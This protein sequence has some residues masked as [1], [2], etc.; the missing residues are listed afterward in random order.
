MPVEIIGEVGTAGAEREWL[1]AQASL[2][3]KQIV[4]KCG[5]PPPEMELELLWQEHELGEYPVIG[6]TWEDGMRGAPAKYISRCQDALFEHEEGE[7][8]PAP[9]VGGIAKK[10]RTKRSPATLNTMSSSLGFIR[11]LCGR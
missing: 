4:K 8:P 10:K 2:A 9:I 11:P 7:P 6:L 3:I 1:A 5:P